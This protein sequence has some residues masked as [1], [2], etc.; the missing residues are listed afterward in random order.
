MAGIPKLNREWHLAHPMPP[1]ATPEQR[2]AW[3]LEHEQNCAC[4]PLTPE[5]REKLRQQVQQHKP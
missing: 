1:K 5:F 3:H 4:R 2:Y